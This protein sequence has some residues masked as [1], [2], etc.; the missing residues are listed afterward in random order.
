MSTYAPK[1]AVHRFIVDLPGRFE[2]G[3]LVRICHPVPPCGAPVTA[4]PSP[5]CWRR[6]PSRA[7]PSATRA[8]PSKAC[9]LR[10]RHGVDPAGF[11]CGDPPVGIE[12][13]PPLGFGL[14]RECELPLRLGRSLR[15]RGWLLDS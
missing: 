8:L 3:C 2:V 6:R 7:W 4:P 10:V 5:A 15:P 11:E 12:V 14:S 9:S 1:S 13:T